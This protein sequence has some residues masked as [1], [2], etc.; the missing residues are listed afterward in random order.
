MAG[1]LGYPSGMLVHGARLLLDPL[2]GLLW[3]D[4]CTLVVADLHF[5]KGSAF[6]RRGVP[7]P[8]YDTR[9]TL[10]RMAEMVRR[11]QPARI[12]CL[13]DSFH[14]LGA[15][16]RLSEEE[17][18]TIEAMTEGR[19]WIWIGGNHD[20]APPDWLPG[21]VADELEIEPLRFRHEPTTGRAAG[22]IAGHLH[23]KAAIR[24][25]GRRVV[26]R[27]FATDGSRLVLPALGAY[28]GGLDVLDDAFRPLFPAPFQA[29]LLGSERIHAVTSSRLERIAPGLSG[30]MPAGA[31]SPP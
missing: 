23:P 21:R 13:G 5:E 6:A 9:A 20:P 26:R 15:P 18:A 25:R 27:C 16:A 14:D 30:P 17:I 19:E 28:A 1:E 22:E 7:L 24:V 4:E 3:P 31:G 12:I 2:G 8:P 11:H 29:L 10:A